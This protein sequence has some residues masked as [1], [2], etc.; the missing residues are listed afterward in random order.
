MPSWRGLN[1]DRKRRQ[2]AS[3]AN[4]VVPGKFYIRISIG[5]PDGFIISCFYR[6]RRL[7]EPLDVH[8]TIFGAVEMAFP[9]SLF[10]RE[11]ARLSRFWALACL[12]SNPRQATAS[13]QQAASLPH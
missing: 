10:N 13:F 3:H 11:A 4:H 8:S 7:N 5:E 9:I 2:S 6:L 1:P 12:L